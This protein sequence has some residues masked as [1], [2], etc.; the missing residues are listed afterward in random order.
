MVPSARST[1]TVEVEDSR[2]T[3]TL[4]R[5]QTT[6]AKRRQILKG[7]R[8]GVESAR[9]CS[10]CIESFPVSHTAHPNPQVFFAQSCAH[11]MRADRKFMDRLTHLR[12]SP[13]VDGKSDGNPWQIGSL[14]HPKSTQRRWVYWFFPTAALNTANTTQLRKLFR[15]ACSVP[16]PGNMHVALQRS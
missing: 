11:D 9:R 12:C 14:S 8:T 1:K 10:S 3:L 4:A 13:L 5:V 7:T 2:I 15:I 16:E 6:R